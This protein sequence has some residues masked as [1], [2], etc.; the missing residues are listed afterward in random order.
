MNFI[1]KNIGYIVLVAAFA[2]FAFV[3]GAKSFI[4][5][6]IF[7]LDKVEDQVM[8]SDEEFN[9]KLKGINVPDA[10]LKDFK[11]HVIF[12]NFWGTWCPPC[13]EEWP[14]IQKLYEA[15]KDKAAFILVAM[16]DKEE[17]IRKFLA[18]KK[19]T[20]PVY[21]AES[22]LSEKMLPKSFPTTFIIGKNGQILQKKDYMYDWNSASVQEFIDQV[23][24]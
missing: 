18:E 7:P 9:M 11:G 6:K 22:P 10:N 1:K 12:L 13:R 3:P 14:T 4:M 24:K 20:V 19:Y 2:V 5:G 8:F 16:Q 17:D 21:V 23:S 15:K